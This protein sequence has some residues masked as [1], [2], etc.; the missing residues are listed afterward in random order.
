MPPSLEE[1][2]KANALSLAEIKTRIVQQDVSGSFFNYA[3]A[4]IAD[5]RKAER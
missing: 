2:G 1:D 5:L 3:N 4:L